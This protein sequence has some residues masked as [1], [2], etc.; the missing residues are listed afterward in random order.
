MSS[1]IENLTL[2]FQI[3]QP[4]PDSACKI[5]IFTPARQE[6][7]SRIAEIGRRLIRCSE[8][9]TTT[10]KRKFKENSFSEK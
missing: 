10:R 7:L 2:G 5:G 4:W 1:S 9:H 3:D 6:T 8:K